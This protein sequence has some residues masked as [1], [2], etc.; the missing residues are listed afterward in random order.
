MVSTV[1]VPCYAQNRSGIPSRDREVLM[2]G[3]YFNG[4][5]WY[6]FKDGAWHDPNSADDPSVYCNV[7][8]ISG[9]PFTRDRRSYIVTLT[10]NPEGGADGRQQY[11][12]IVFVKVEG[13]GKIQQQARIACSLPIGNDIYKIQ[14]RNLICIT[15]KEYASDDP[16]CCPSLLDESTYSWDNG[17]VKLVNT[18]Q[19]RNPQAQN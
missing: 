2:N 13:A 5:K 6:Q 12:L 1:V 15:G 16:N 17:K 3:R 18:R 7:N 10:M 11:F 8:S 9:N 4:E 14:G 19:I